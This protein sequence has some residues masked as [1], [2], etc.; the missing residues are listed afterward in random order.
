MGIWDKTGMIEIRQSAF[1]VGE[2][3]LARATALTT[4]ARC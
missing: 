3:V 1:D 4:P 2:E